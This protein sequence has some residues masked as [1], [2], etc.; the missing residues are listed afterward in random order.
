MK[1][2]TQTTEKV[3]APSEA[4]R[5]RENIRFA[6]RWMDGHKLYGVK[7]VKGDAWTQGGRI[8]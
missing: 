6:I 1:I 3:N 8:A 4:V 5:Q 2:K 7:H